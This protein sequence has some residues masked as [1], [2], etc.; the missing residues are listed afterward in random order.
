[1]EKVLFFRHWKKE[2]AVTLIETVVALSL[3]TIVSVAAVS[4]AIY[5]ANSFRIASVKRFFN[6][7]LDSI[8]EIYVAYDNESDFRKAFQLHTG[9]EISGYTNTIY[10]LDNSLS[11]LDDSQGSSFYIS[12]SFEGTKLDMGSYSN[13]GTTLAQRSVTK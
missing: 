7:E 3:I 9:K 1:M 2:K 12:L 6:H 11:Y 8:S 4:V 13:S 5:S 10:Y